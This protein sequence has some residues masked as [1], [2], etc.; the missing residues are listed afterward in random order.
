MKIIFSRLARVLG[1]VALLVPAGAAWAQWELDGTKS[2][3]NFISIKN[4]SVAEVHSFTSLVGYIGED[5]KVQLSVGLASVETLVAIRNDRMRE[6]LFET[7][8]FPAA[9]ITTTVAP[10]IIAAAAEGGTVI[11]DLTLSLEL[12]GVQKSLTV[13]VVLVGESIG[14]IQVFTRSPVIINAADFNLEA[15]VAALQAVAGLKAISSAVPV[16][17]HLVFTTAK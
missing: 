17:V 10:D 6:M 12:H 4:D 1:V 9:T 7:A 11:T 5:G 3:V 2:A 14:R 13:P 16:T 15:G 8:N